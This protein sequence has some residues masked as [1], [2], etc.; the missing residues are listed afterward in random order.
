MQSQTLKQSSEKTA[1]KSDSGKILSFLELGMW[2][3][4]YE[5]QH[6]SRLSNNYEDLCAPPAN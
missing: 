3:R 4:I 2:S 6:S 1:E 5:S